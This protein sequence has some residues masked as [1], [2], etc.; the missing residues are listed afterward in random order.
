M[1]H[2]KGHGYIRY[3]VGHYRVICSLHD[4]VLMIE[5]VR[6]GHRSDVYKR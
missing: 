5:V 1:F 2:R 3:S 4:D 6:V